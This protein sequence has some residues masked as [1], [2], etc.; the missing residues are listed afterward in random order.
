MIEED[1]K[2]L[3][4]LSKSEAIIPPRGHIN[5]ITDKWWIVH[6]TKGY[7][8]WKSFTSPQCNSNKQ[9]TEG[10]LAMYPWA[11]VEFAKSVFTPLDVQDYL[12]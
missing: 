1:S 10:F 7:V 12:P 8:F 2:H 6:P 4:F 3:I 5:H 9:I 11:Q